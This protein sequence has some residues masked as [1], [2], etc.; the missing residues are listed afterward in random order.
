MLLL[1]GFIVPKSKPKTS[2]LQALHAWKRS[3]AV[4]ILAPW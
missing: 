3:F 2:L 1:C 4:T